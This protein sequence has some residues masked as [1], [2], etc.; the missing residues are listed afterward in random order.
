VAGAEAKS[1]HSQSNDA[2]QHAHEARAEADRLQAE[3]EDAHRAYL[4]A[5]AK[6]AASESRAGK[7]H[8]SKED[9]DAARQAADADAAHARKCES[10]WHHAEA[11][12]AHA[13][14]DAAAAEE[15]AARST[16]I[17]QQ[18]DTKLANAQSNL[19]DADA[20]VKKA[21]KELKLSED[22]EKLFADYEKSLN[23]NRGVANEHEENGKP[24]G[25]GHAPPKIK[26]SSFKKDHMGDDSSHRL[27]NKP[28][29][30]N[31]KPVSKGG[32]PKPSKKDKPAD[33][34]NEVLKKNRPKWGDVD[35]DKD[36]DVEKALRDVLDAS[37]EDMIREAKALL[38]HADE[39]ASKNQA[40]ADIC[41]GLGL[42]IQST[43]Q[44]G[45]SWVKREADQ[46]GSQQKTDES[47]AQQF[48]AFA[49]SFNELA[50]ACKAII[51]QLATAQAIEQD[52][53]SVVMH[54][55][56]A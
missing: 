52:A 2:A 15:A 3:S 35:V 48:N 29:D 10:E 55:A 20:A 28:G 4:S 51:D 11:N 56:A 30:D 50:Q 31:R 49:D 25:A 17:A 14:E 41:R 22:D 46:A 19:N 16:S 33:P 5:A 36:V 24:S 32:K 38:A 42:L 9:G 43:G 23:E 18:A 12:A 34:S 8:F 53:H 44:F 54:A 1:A 47:A 27:H 26:H 21:Q 6:A 45:G 7:E 37:P 39:K 40:V 13:N